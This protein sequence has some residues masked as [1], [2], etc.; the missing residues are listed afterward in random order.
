MIFLLTC[1]S[2]LI[3]KEKKSNF[4]NES[5]GLTL[6]A[7]FFLPREYMQDSQETLKQV[8]AKDRKKKINRR[9]AIT[10]YS[11][12]VQK[13]IIWYSSLIFL[14]CL[15]ILIDCFAGVGLWVLLTRLV[16]HQQHCTWHFYWTCSLPQGLRLQAIAFFEQPPSFT[17][18]ASPVLFFRP[19]FPFNKK[20]ESVT[21]R[22]LPQTSATRDLEYSC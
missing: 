11:S 10:D 8:L 3:V 15:P 13:L 19:L 7:Q 5:W 6:K 14:Y 1:L 4:H 22:P 20:A 17:T 18:S 9:K 12:S 16:T 21:H 2:S